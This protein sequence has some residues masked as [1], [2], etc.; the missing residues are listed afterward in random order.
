VEL[1]HGWSGWWDLCEARRGY[2][3]LACIV[4]FGGTGPEEEAAV[5]SC[6]RC[7]SSY[8]LFERVY[9]RK[10]EKS[11]RMGVGLV[12]QLAEWQTCTQSLNSWERSPA[13]AWATLLRKKTKVRMGHNETGRILIVTAGGRGSGPCGG[14]EC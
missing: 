7:K 11:V 9:V 5:E 4:A 2:D 14:F 6:E 10:R 13:E 1:V 3:V 8:S 12:P